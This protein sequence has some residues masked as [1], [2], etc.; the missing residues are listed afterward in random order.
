M[1]LSHD[2]PEAGCIAAELNRDKGGGLVAA[3][4][5]EHTSG[6]IWLH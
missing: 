5:R 1:E 4:G 3:L 2:R 6:G